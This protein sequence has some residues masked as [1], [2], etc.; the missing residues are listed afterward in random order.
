[1]R[2][3][4]HRRHRGSWNGSAYPLRR[5]V[6]I[7]LCLLPE[8][9]VRAKGIASFH[10]ARR[11]CHGSAGDSGTTISGCR[12]RPGGPARPWLAWWSTTA[13]SMRSGALRSPLPAAAIRL[14][15]GNYL[16]RSPIGMGYP[17]TPPDSCLPVSSC[18]NPARIL[19]RETMHWSP[20]CAS[21]SP[22]FRGCR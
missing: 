7:V 8:R 1:M 20:R 17:A 16:D 9:S 11:A 14:H 6:A 15:N 12:P 18:C 13:I 19:R 21:H 2:K 22:N 5:N 3:T 10:C 4:W